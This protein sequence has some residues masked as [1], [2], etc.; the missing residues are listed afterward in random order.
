MQL[1]ADVLS[2]QHNQDNLSKQLKDIDIDWD[3]VVAVASQHLML[4]ALYC[5]LKEKGLLALIPEDL[6]VYLEE[7]TGIN[8]GRNEI[9]LNEVY[10]ISEILKKENIDHVFIKGAAL[11]ANE[12]FKDS[13]ERMIGDI[14]ILVAEHQCYT[15]FDI[16]TKNGYSDTV[17][18][19]YEQKH[20]RHLPR[21]ISQQKFGAIEIHSEVLCHKQKQLLIGKYVLQNKRI[22]NGIAI[23]SAEDSIKISILALQIND[24]AHLHGYFSFKTIYDCL[25]L[26]LPSKLVLFKDLVNVKYAQSFLKLS[27]IFFKELTPYKTSNYSTLLQYYYQFRL[28]HP[29]SGNLIA[30]LAKTFTNTIIRVKLVFNNQS[31]RRHILKNKIIFKKK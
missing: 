4:P 15:A 16:L 18:F 24:K 3:G 17:T 26:E 20:F 7:I 19:N 21:Q 22:G 10:E 5:R 31:Y 9:L 30:L 6:N 11:L 2:F 13:A 27:S 23:P 25:A 12:T 1:I 29:K 8:R 28:K 14:D